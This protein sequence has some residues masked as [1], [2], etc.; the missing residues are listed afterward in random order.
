MGL[1]KRKPLDNERVSSI[2]V[3]AF[4]VYTIVLLMV[5]PAGIG[6]EGTGENGGMI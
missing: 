3:K 2:R 6:S 5:L 1:M 4:L